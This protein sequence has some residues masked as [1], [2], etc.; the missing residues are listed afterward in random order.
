MSVYVPIRMRK[1]EFAQVRKV[2]RPPVGRLFPMQNAFD[3]L[4]KFAGMPSHSLILLNFLSK[5]N[6]EDID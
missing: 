6:A 4:F 3:L 2:A 1:H 5:W